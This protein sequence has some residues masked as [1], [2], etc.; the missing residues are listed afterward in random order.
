MPA[1]TIGSSVV[2]IGLRILPENEM[3]AF[4]KSLDVLNS[5]SN[6][7]RWLSRLRHW[8][9]KGHADKSISKHGVPAPGSYGLLVGRG[10][11]LPY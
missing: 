7:N 3:A 11:Q 10:P 8:A 5:R 4:I 1:Q 6:A 2:P 9:G